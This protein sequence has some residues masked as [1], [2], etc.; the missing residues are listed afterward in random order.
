MVEE[1]EAA[2]VDTYAIMADLTGQAT[3]GAVRA[4]DEI[5]VGKINGIVHYLIVCELAYH[6]RRG[7]LPFQSEKELREFISTYFTVKML[8]P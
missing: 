7:R 2:I 4:L 6:W 3:N 5:R 8:N 1:S